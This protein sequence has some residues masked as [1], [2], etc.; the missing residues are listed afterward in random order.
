MEFLKKMISAFLF[1][2]KKHITPDEFLASV[3][4]DFGR[5][6]DP[7][8][9]FFF[10]HHPVTVNLVFQIMNGKIGFKNPNRNRIIMQSLMLEMDGSIFKHEYE[11]RPDTPISDILQ[12]FTKEYKDAGN[13]VGQSILRI[14]KGE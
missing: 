10:L 7:E 13:I 3:E 5:E 2:R 1:R 9:T 11:L 4:S 8:S 6:L 12:N 14:M